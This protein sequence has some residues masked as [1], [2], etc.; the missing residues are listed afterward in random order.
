[1]AAAIVKDAAIGAQISALRRSFA[2]MQ[3]CFREEDY[4]DAAVGLLGTL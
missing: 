1:M 2:T 4:P 3:Y